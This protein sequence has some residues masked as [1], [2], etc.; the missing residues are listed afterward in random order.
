M[1]I[2]RRIGIAFSPD[3]HESP[4]EPVE[5]GQEAKQG[6]FARAALAD[7]DG[8]AGSRGLEGDIERERISLLNQVSVEHGQRARRAATE[9]V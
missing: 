8:G 3:R 9:Q 1:E 5:P 4:V 7:D 2:A 6:C